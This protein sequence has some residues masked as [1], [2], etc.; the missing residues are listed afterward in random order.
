MYCLTIYTS[1]NVALVQVT[2]Q[3]VMT[4]SK[5]N[6]AGSVLYE[7]LRVILFNIERRVIIPHKYSLFK[8]CLRKS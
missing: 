5:S 6:V 1:F 4:F 2:F 7:V 3:S 8:T